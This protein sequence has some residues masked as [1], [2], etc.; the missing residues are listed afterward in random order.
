MLDRN[1][2]K[3]IS[4]LE[5]EYNTKGM[6]IGGVVLVVII[7][8]LCLLIWNLYHKEEGTVSG[9]NSSVN[10]PSEGG[11]DTLGNGHGENDG[12][13]P[14]DETAGSGASTTQAT[15]SSEGQDGQDGQQEASSG[16][17]E[18][19]DQGDS[20]GGQAG[21]Q[22]G[23]QEG[24]G[25]NQG[26]GT[27]PDTPSMAF[28]DVDETVTAKETTN[29]RSAP[30]TT[31]NDTVVT[32]LRNGETAKRTGINEE[33]GWSRLEYNGQTLYAVS[34]LLTT[35][36]SEREEDKKPSDTVTTASGRK[37]T[38]TPCDDTVTPKIECNLRSEPSTDQS[39]QTVRYL[40][41]NGEKI[42]RTGYDEASGWSRVE[43]NG[44]T[45]YLVSSLVNV[46]EEP[47][48]SSGQQ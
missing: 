15:D 11:S 41:K 37:I 17:P 12:T 33:T 7:F 43:Y 42:H 21:N 29:L 32:K 10:Q 9:N 26:S 46:V 25:D 3:K 44:E 34:R 47:A 36:L 5:S 18:G 45:L 30:G 8:I 22:G 16:A 20:Q 38:F 24:Q 1:E 2:N 28:A 35:D 4:G 31:G 27:V 14:S 6:I 23:S 13:V 19:E 40:L 48:E 39:D